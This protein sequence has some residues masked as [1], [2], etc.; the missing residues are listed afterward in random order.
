MTEEIWYKNI[1]GFM[2]DTDH[3]LEFIPDR[4]MTLDQ[5]LNS[6]L[7]FSLYLSIILV[8]IRQDIRPIF[9]TFFIA[10]LT[11][12]IH[13]QQNRESFLK[14]S[15]YDTLNIDKDIKDRACYKPTK[16]NPFMNYMQGDFV[17]R[18]KACDITEKDSKYAVEMNKFF[19]TNGTFVR[20]T[21][22][23]YNKAASDRQFYTTPST[24]ASND[25]ESFAKFLYPLGKTKKEDGLVNFF[26]PK[27][28]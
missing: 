7:R 13:A 20:A 19:E 26:T 2:T 24:T 9:I 28:H 6:I 5:Q 22:D 1:Y 16:E 14:S 27:K 15:L 11:W 17:N 12:L 4:S 18:P 21:D 10:L 3:Y 23:I 8:V 25:F